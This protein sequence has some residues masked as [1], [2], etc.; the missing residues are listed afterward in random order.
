MNEIIKYGFWFLAG[1]AAAKAGSHLLSGQETS[2]RTAAVGTV[3]QGLAAKDKVLTSMEKA[4]ENV[5]D[6]IAEAKHVQTVANNRNLNQD[7]TD[8]DAT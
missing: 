6:I 4:R 3:A 5:E 1:F 8:M 7:K 2:L